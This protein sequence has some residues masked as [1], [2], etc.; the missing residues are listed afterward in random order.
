MFDLLLAKNYKLKASKCAFAF[1]EISFLG[2]TIG[3]GVLKTDPEKIA[4]IRDFPVL[5]NTTELLRFL[6]IVLWYARFIPKLSDIAAPLHELLKKEPPDKPHKWEIDDS[7]T[8]Q[9]KVS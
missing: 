9:N 5:T 4:K 2:Y 8:P 6:G 3:Q 1:D 7:G